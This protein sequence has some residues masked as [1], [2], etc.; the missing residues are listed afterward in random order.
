MIMIGANGVTDSVMAELDSTLTHHELLK[1][2]IA[3]ND[4][5]ERAAT[6]EHIVQQTGALLVQTIGKTCVIY[7]Q[8]EETE[9]PLPK[10]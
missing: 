8:N 3:S 1:I 5:I 6:V 4:R 9:L 2:K 7:R 10:K